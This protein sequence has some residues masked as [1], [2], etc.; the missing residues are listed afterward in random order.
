MDPGELLAR[1]L[2]APPDSAER[3]LY[4]TAGFGAL[5]EADMV[6]VGGGAQVTHTGVGRVTDIDVTGTVT[7]ADEERLAFAGFRREGRHWVLEGGGGAIAVEVPAA[8]SL[9]VEPPERIDVEGTPVSVI[10]VTDLM[11]DRL[12]QATD[13]TPVT[14]DEALQLAVAAHDR[15]NWERLGQ[16][17]VDVA[18]AEPFLQGLPALVERFDTTAAHLLSP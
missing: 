7:P 1:A 17:A 6:L 4:A 10:S 2:N 13:G 8:E 11:M 15:I 18:A 16:R 9:G 3:I 12:I 14:R 5:V